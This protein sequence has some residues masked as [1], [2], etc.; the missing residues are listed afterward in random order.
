MLTSAELCSSIEPS[1]EPLA[2]TASAEYS[3][4]LTFAAGKE[5][6]ILE[7][8][9]G[10]QGLKNAFAAQR[11]GYWVEQVKFRSGKRWSSIHWRSSRAV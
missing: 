10:F 4:P 11:T 1:S 5:P 3:D 9:Y 2:Y 6:I 7:S 8:G